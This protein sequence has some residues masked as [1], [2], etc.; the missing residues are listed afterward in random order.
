MVY[1]TIQAAHILPVSLARAGGRVGEVGYE[2]TLSPVTLLN[3][4]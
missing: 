2:L 4:V 3:G 1:D